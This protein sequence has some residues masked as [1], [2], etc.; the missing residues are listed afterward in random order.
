MT[1]V[2]VTTTGGAKIH[3][4]RHGQQTNTQF[5]TGRMPFLPSNKQ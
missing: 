5:F 3:S 2:V 1:E 4:I